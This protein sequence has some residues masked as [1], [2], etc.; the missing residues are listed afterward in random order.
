MERIASFL[1]SHRAAAVSTLSVLGIAVLVPLAI[2]DYRIY[3][4]YGPGGLPYN[5]KGWLIANTLRLLSQEQLST[6]IYSDL[7]LPFADMPGFL[8]AQ[9]PQ[10]R[11]SRPKIG[12]HPAP[13]R[14]LEQLP[15]EVT[16]KELIIR[17]E[18][19]GQ[20]AQAKGLVEVRQSLFERQHS[21]LFVSKARDWHSVAQ[22]TRGE[23]SHVHAGLDGS[24][25]VS[26]HPTDCKRVISMGWGQRHAL[27]GIAVL[28][29]M[30]GASLPVNY[31]L[32]YAP[33]DEV[34]IEVAMTIVRASVD[35]MTWTRDTL[36]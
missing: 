10:R 11:S 25:H 2:Q 31:L 22:Q 9:F 13:Q 33:R 15:D 1:A 21:A 20:Q 35:F 3:L 32:I 30:V 4:S 16:R 26:L 29:K 27:D 14:Q 24:I 19:L 6:R 5:I 12:P 18:Q 34:E 23:I 28:K 7:K 36:E 17:F 8:P